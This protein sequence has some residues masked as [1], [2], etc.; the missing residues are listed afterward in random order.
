ML[1]T[2]GDRSPLGKRWQKP[3]TG[4]CYSTF[5]HTYEVPLNAFTS[6]EGRMPF[7]ESLVPCEDEVY[8]VLLNLDPSKFPG[9]HGLPTIVLKTCAREL[10]PSPCV[11]FNLS[12]AEGKLPTE[13]KD[14]LVDPLHTK[15]KKGGCYYNY[16]PIFYCALYPKY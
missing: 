11:L 6:P 16:R 3:S 9:P 8:K 7:L 13:W 2:V 1:C 14:A 12:L 15:G 10:T 5:M 4:I